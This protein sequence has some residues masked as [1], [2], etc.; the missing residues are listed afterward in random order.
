[1]V[2]CF[3]YSACNGCITIKPNLIM[4]YQIGDTVELVS[5]QKALVQY[6]EF[7]SKEKPA[8]KIGQR[9]KVRAISKSGWL[10]C[11]GLE[12][13]HPSENFKKISNGNGS[14][15]DRCK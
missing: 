3:N 6:E 12:Y 9:F 10:L 11:E 4:N 2:C 7:F 15:T 14:E 5:M 1:M 8:P 13:F